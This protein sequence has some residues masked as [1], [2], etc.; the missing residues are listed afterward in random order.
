MSDVTT[1]AVGII[2]RF[3]RMILEEQVRLRRGVYYD[4]VPGDVCHACAIGTLWLA[5]E[6]RPWGLGV[7]AS[8]RDGCLAKH[9]AL[10]LAYNALNEAA[11]NSPRFERY[12]SAFDSDLEY[13]FE[14]IGVDAAELVRVADAAEALLLAD[15]AEAVTAGGER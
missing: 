4:A 3:R 11:R 13:L 10:E 14:A 8:Q 5:A 15:R 7:F 1:E 6:A 9:P 2:Q 12:S